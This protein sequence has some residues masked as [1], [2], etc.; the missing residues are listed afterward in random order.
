MTEDKSNQPE[1]TKADS[2]DTTSKPDIS[3]AEAKAK[4][5]ESKVVDKVVIRGYPKVVLFWPMLAISV[6]FFFLGGGVSDEPIVSASALAWWWLLVFSG[7]LMIH[8][9]DFGRNNF[10]AAIAIGGV[11]LL[12]LWVWDL[13]TETEVY[14]SIFQFFRDHEIAMHANFYAAIAGIFSVMIF[15]A[16]LTT[17]FNY[18]I[19]MPNRVTHKRGLLGDERHYATI[20]MVVDKEIPDVFEWILFGSGRLVFKPGTG[21]DQHQSLIVDNV[22]RVGSIEKRVHEFLGIIKVDEDRNR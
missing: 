5:T 15:C 7:N 21:S 12:G 9:F 13:Q 11:S 22:F 10:V 3:V 6:V 19:L 8:T 18:W 16:W 2:T 14:G 4:V 20:N 17:R 1:T